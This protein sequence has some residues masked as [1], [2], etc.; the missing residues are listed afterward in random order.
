LPV[1]RGLALEAG[2]RRRK[3]GMMRDAIFTAEEK[4]CEE[5]PA[6]R[7]IP[8]ESPCQVVLDMFAFLANPYSSTDGCAELASQ[9]L[10]DEDPPYDALMESMSGFAF[11]AVPLQS[12]VDAHAAL[13][14]ELE[15]FDPLRLASCFGALLTEP[16]LQSSGVRL[17]TLV[18]LALATAHGTRK[19]NDKIIARLF[20]ALGDGIPGTLEDPAE[21]IFVSLIA[22]PRGNFR[23]LEGIWESAGFHT[24]RIVNA[25]ELIPKGEP[26]DRIRNCVYAMLKLS[27]LVCE[28]AGLRRYT[29][30][31]PTPLDKIPPKILGRLQS[32]RRCIRFT[33]DD[34]SANGIALSDLAEFGYDPRARA[35][36]ASNRIGHSA[37]ERS[38][39]VHRN[40][41]FYLL[42]PTAASAALRRFVIESIEHIGLRDVFE[43]TLAYELGTLIAKIPLLGSRTGA[44]MEFR[45]TDNGLL[46]GVMTPADRGL[47][48]NF[49]FYADTLENFGE[50][51]LVGI[52]PTVTRSGL[53]KDIVTWIDEA[54]ESASKLPD[55]RAGLTLLVG[56]GIGRA[57]LDLT[58]DKEWD[59]WRVESIAAP[60]LLTLSWLPDFKPLSLWRLLAGRDR[61]EELGVSLFNVNG[62]LNLVAWARSLGGHLVPHA[63]VPAEFVAGG[64]SQFIMVE[65]NALLQIRQ[66]VTAAWDEHACLDIH[67]NWLTVR[68]DGQSIFKEDL[69][70]PFYV[71]VDEA[72]SRWPLCVYETTRRPW[73][74]QLETDDETTG[75]WAYQRFQLLRTWICLAAPVLDEAFPG[76]S[77]GPVLW[78]AKF[79]GHIGDKKSKKDRAFLTAEQTLPFIEM[80][81]APP[82]ISMTVREGFEDAIYNPEN[83]AERALVTRF[84]EGIAQLAGAAIDARQREAIVDRIVTSPSARQSHAFM[85]R[86]FRDYV[87]RSVWNS[88]VEIDTD[89]S[90]TMKL[91]LGWRTRDRSEGGEV[92][93]QQACTAY[94]NSVVKI[95]EDEICSDLRSLDRRSVI[96]FALLNHE[97][98]IAD[99][100]NWRRTAAAVVALHKDKET[101]LDTI[102]HHEAELN[103]IFQATRLLVEFAICECPLNGGRKPGRLDLSRLMAKIMM[104]CGMGG[105]S[106]AIHWQAMEPLVRI[107]PLGDIHANVTFQEEVLNPYGRAASDL[108]VEEN[109]KNYADNLTEP[110]ASSSDG[111]H[112]DNDFWEAFE[113]QFGAGFD[114]AKKFVDFVEDMGVNKDAAV[115]AVKRSELLNVSFEGVQLDAA[116]VEALADFFTFKGRARWRDVPDGYI[117]KD[118]FPWRYRR[119]L[120]VLRKP[121]IQL[122]ESD[123]PLMIV[124]P[125]ILRD[126]FGY[127]FR[128]YHRG[129]FPRWQLSPKMKRWAGKSRKRMGE[130]FSSEVAARLRELGWKVE[131][132][133][134]RV[135]ELLGKKFDKDYGDIDVL[136]WNESTGRVLLI[137]CKDVQHR[138][139]DGEIAEQLLDFRGELGAD[140]KPDLLLKHLNRVELISKHVPEVM[141]YLKLESRPVLEGHLVFKNPVPMK[142]AWKRMQERINLNLFSDL[143]K[144]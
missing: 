143:E 92:T 123:D 28:R 101:T 71:S 124:A 6:I 95:L 102:A 61:L 55:F 68:R 74:I 140:G 36:L 77:S 53:E 31:E 126:A 33:E 117:E 2:A 73:W 24:Q 67:G 3:V 11:G 45:R 109:I 108:T 142:F 22:T 94:L 21:D 75:Y 14:A 79:E 26:Y 144:I 23:I 30:G 62:L 121:L 46:A 116:S 59:N 12:V 37:L 84:V 110:V 83:V 89:D 104:T 85:A 44:P 78:K 100:D 119:R 105:W 125:G 111:S 4:D 51:G 35:D 112:I 141:T 69:D 32:L 131:K 58:P 132:T 133:E 127:M 5:S 88:P 86:N 96:M 76:L 81:M 27:D 17:E 90:A 136:A 114:T 134:L 64:A 13:F 29:R 10:T 1:S 137:E 82:V 19:P 42:L 107:T 138:K 52:Y 80:E 48:V 8:S 39:V 103:A 34:L 113:E 16:S 129:D 70:R 15:P 98:A 20:S 25:L 93:G 139:T 122:D 91:G 40:G 57:V 9:D 72:A 56:C 63:S 43:S 38:P 18:H 99:R 97:S 128:N 49:V 66:E 47:F 41:D 54:Y 106:D 60:D 135:T 118:L 115:F 87:R 120:S 65:Q 7:P 50:E 130:E